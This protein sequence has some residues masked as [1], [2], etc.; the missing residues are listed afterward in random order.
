MI[1][2]IDTGIGNVPSVCSALKKINSNFILC[3]SKKDI[4]RVSKI[5]L[6][7][8]GSFKTFYEKIQK[9][10]IFYEISS[11]V[12]NGT[13]ILGIC[14]GFHA[15]FESSSEF[16]KFEGFKF[17]RGEVENIKNLGVTEKIPHVGWN[18]CEIK[19]NS[20]IFN[21]I[22]SKTNFY[23][24]HSFT[25]V[26]VKKENII[27]TVNYGK[28]L[29]VAVQNKNIFGVQF[30]PEKSQKSGLQLIKNFVENCNA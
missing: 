2:V 16:G 24:T 5:I 6:P 18:D 12:K 22:K 3:S 30:H 7:G 4:D 29:V 27:G 23:F 26:N 9:K 8:V 1:G 13:P 14:L 17:I 28:E 19:K 11:R 20:E 15:L 10:N 25:P 21:E